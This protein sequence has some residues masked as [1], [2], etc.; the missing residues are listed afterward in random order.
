MSC[1]KLVVI[2]MVITLVQGCAYMTARSSQMLEKVDQ[3][4]AAQ[5]YGQARKVLSSV[6]PS[7]VDYLKAQALLDE[8]NKQALSFEQQV[9]QQGG[10]LELAGKWYLA[11][12][13]YQ[14]GLSRLPDSEPIRSTLQALQVKQSSRIAALELALLIAQGEW[15]KQNLVIQNERSL[16]TSNNWFKEKQRE[17]MVKEAL[18]TAAALR[19]RGELALE[20]NELSLAERVLNLAWQ[21]DPSPAAEEGLQAL[22]TKQKMIMNIAQQSKAAEAE[23]QRQ[24]ILASRRHMREILLTSFREALA[25]RQLSQASGFVTRLKLLGELND[26]ERQLE[27]QLELLIKQQ[28]EAGIDEGVEYYGL[29]QYEQAI[30]SWKKVLL[31][32]PENRQALEHIA[33]AERILEKLQRLRDNKNQE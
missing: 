4:I 32:E 29:A 19:E 6:P 14:K 22:A 28:V 5:Q 7:H 18:K 15:L 9:L 26:D 8:V 30:A 16:L 17:E 21:L 27:R 25:D 31:L 3:M 13:H 2:I 24:A 33:R 1:V 10:E 23:R 11:M 12:Q 20:Q